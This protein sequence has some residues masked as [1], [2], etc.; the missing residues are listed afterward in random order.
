MTTIQKRIIRSSMLHLLAVTVLAI[1]VFISPRSVGF[2]IFGVIVLT[3]T[4]GI[5]MLVIAKG[6]QV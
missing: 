5:S 6:R 4:W 2:G 3:V 1:M